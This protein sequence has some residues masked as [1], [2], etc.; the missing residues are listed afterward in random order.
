[1]SG[2]AQG[3]EGMGS[4][5][6]SLLSGRRRVVF[7]VSMMMAVA[8]V[9][10][11]SGAGP[12]GAKP[13]GKSKPSGGKAMVMVNAR[14]AEAPISPLLTGVNNDQWFEN[15]H[16]LWDPE[17]EQPDS[18][19]VEKT[20]RAGIDIVRYPGGT[21]ASFY[22]WK[23]AIGPQA[24]RSCQTDARPGNGEPRDSVY[25]PD[26]HMEFVGQAGAGAQ[27][28]VPFVSET[29]TDAADWVE[30]MNA[31]V[32]TNPNGGT[33]WAEER[34]AN[35]H[36]EPHGVNYWE[37][38]NEHD[39]PDQRYWMS[40]DNETALEQYAFGGTQ[41]QEGQLLGK[42]CDFSPDVASDGEPN[43]VFSVAFPPVVPDSA[44]VF[45]DGEEWR[46]VE[47]L[48]SAGPDDEVYEFDP[49]SGEAAFGDG[50]NGK[51]PPTD[52]QV[53]ADYDSG[54]H[55]GFV[56]FYEAMKE[57]DPGIDVCATWAPINAGTGLGTANFPELMAENGRSDDYDCLIFHPYTNFT[58]Q[59]DNVFETAREGHDEHMLGEAEATR[60][61][62][63]HA[64]S[65]EEY[66]REDAYVTVSELGALFFGPNDARAYPSW[67]TA[68]SHATYFASQW[69]RLADL[70]VPWAE[71]NTLVSEVPTGL[72][73]V[74]GGEPRF[75]FTSEAVV[76]ESIKPL[77]EGGG[78][79]VEHRVRKN[80]LVE[81]H[82]TQLGS[83]YEALTSTATLDEDGQLNILVVNR[84]PTDAVEAKVMPAGFRHGTTANVSTVDGADNLDNNRESFESHNSLRNPE[85]VRLERGEIQTGRGPFDYAFPK[86]S[87]TLIQL[88]PEDRRP[89]GP[90]GRY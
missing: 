50:A 70:G 67:N 30:Y 38:G 57:A 16:G 34:A 13:P 60:I 24:S 25:G 41:R 68:M 35:G 90:P 74:L 46:E 2:D 84:H 78:D 7:L 32:G 80:P 56:D 81:T 87:V 10:V 86:H 9:F 1:M 82:E 17:R 14:K 8:V 27:I 19:V 65:V 26:E 62:R 15:A 66:G 12:S 48:S 79:V 71:G 72:R 29:A 22:D 51:V 43:Q 52:T 85:E 23:R 54:P 3:G 31:P 88:D 73:A 21:P 33:A 59:F 20:E 63:E 39:R 42:G 53:T 47:S 37:V 75:I 77:V 6:R 44:T 40:P 55:D 18:R 4:A 49:E 83:S 28:M 11:A 61:L 45:V 36:P 58:T 64:E 5:G 69:T 89:P 76:R